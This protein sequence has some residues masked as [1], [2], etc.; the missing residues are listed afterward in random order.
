VGSGVPTLPPPLFIPDDAGLDPNLILSEMIAAF[1]TAAGRKLQPAQVE[2]LLINLYAY[3]ESLVRA[4]IQFAAE[5]NLLAFARFPM[6][7]FLGQLLGVTRLAAQKAV[8]VL[9]FT[10]T[11]ALG[12]QFT[13]PSGTQVATQDQQFKFATDEQLLFE[14]GET[15]KSVTA[16]ATEAG[17]G[18]NG[19]VTGQVNVMVEPNAQIA[20]ATNTSATSGGSAQ[21]NDEQLRQR[22]QTAPNRFSSAGPAGAYGFFA[23]GVDPAFAAVQVIT[24]VPG[25][26]R[27][28]VLTGPITVQPAAAPNSAGIANSALLQKLLDALNAET[29]RPLTDTVQTNAVTEVDYLITATIRLFSNA[30]PE[31]TMAAANEA[32]RQFALA[33]ANRIGRDLVRTQLFDALH[34]SGVYRVDLT[35]PAADVILGNGQWAN[36]TAITLAQA[37]DSE[38][39]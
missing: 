14:I 22:I 5:Q 26:V 31:T 18:A 33:R 23:L 39:S 19:Y 15:V 27:V 32:A 13:I 9:Q 17:A 37:T 24:P 1:E 21:E 4:A 38:E 8:T 34:V 10:L 3:R 30:D 12:T 7:D 6:L 16:T 20:S 2:R 36:C 28:Y 35:A 29:I 25:T 11:G